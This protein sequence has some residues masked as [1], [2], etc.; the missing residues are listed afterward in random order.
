[1]RTSRVDSP[2]YILREN[3]LRLA[4]NLQKYAEYLK[5]MKET[6][7]EAHKRKIQRTDEYE[8]EVFEPQVMNPNLSSWYKTLNQTLLETDPYKPIFLNEY[9]PTDR[10]LK[11]DYINGL[12]FSMKVIRFA[13]TSPCEL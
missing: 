11:F 10:R 4:D 5:G 2:F 8:W 3:I 12:H 6:M 9:A 7:S 13:Y 1:M